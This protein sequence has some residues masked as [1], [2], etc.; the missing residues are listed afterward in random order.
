M[1]NWLVNRPP[2]PIPAIAWGIGS[3]RHGEITPWPDPKGFALVGVREADQGRAEAGTWVPCVSC[4]SP[5]FDCSYLKQHEAVLF[6]NA[7]P[8]IMESYPAKVGGLPT[9]LNNQPM[10]KVVAF[11]GSAETIVTNSY[12]GIYWGTLLGRQVVA[13]PYSSKFYCIRF[14]PAYSR[15][16]GLDWFRAART[17]LTWP[18]ALE[19]CR[20]VTRAFYDRVMWFLNHEIG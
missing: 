10:G 5:L 20:A 19:E 4:M 14:P 9:M 18:D 2:P 11:L 6:L 15:D 17:G 12:H 7:S 13:L 16:G 1:N 3:S 8:S